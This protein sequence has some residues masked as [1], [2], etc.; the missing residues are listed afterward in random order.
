MAAVVNV[1]EGNGAPTGVWNIVESPRFCTADNYN[2]GSQNPLVKPESGSNYSY[3][4]SFRLYTGGTAAVT[5]INNIKFFSDGE[6]S[7]TG[8]TINS[9]LVTTYAQAT[10]TE[11]TTG[12]VMSGGT[13]VFTYT[14]AAPLSV[15]QSMGDISATTIN[16]PVSDIVEM[17]AVVGA[18]ASTPGAGETFTFR[19]DET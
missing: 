1:R 16:S 9:K 5:N 7:W 2:P 4:K 6:S 15:T 3:K 12:D 10:G 17:Q 19:Y 18:T 13:D 14:T 8:I 11:G